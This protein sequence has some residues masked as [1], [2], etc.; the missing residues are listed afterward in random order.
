MLITTIRYSGFQHS[1]N[2]TSEIGLEKPLGTVDLDVRY[3]PN[4]AELLLNTSNDGLSIKN[5]I[6]SQSINNGGV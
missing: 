2:I 3:S 5:I 1:T 4:E 6:K